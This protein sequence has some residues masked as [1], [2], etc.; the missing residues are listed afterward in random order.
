MINLWTLIIRPIFDYGVCFAHLLEN[1][2]INWY[3][4]QIKKSFKRVL[5]IRKSTPDKVV[6][7]LMGYD[8]ALFASHQVRNA[9]VRWQERK[10]KRTMPTE[11]LNSFRIAGSSVLLSWPLL[12]INNMLFNKCQKHTCLTTPQHLKD[13]HGIQE[14]PS[15]E[16]IMDQGIEID[17]RLKN[18]KRKGR[19]FKTIEEITN[20]HLKIFELC[21]NEL[22]AHTE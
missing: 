10:T 8:P 15:I 19:V 21:C 6:E 13:A 1:S 3:I 16:A 14:I 9:E 5:G 4:T 2:K 20:G 17:G 18:T 12:K 22:I 11:N 7:K